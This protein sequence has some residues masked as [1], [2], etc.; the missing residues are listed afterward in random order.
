M[1]PENIGAATLGKSVLQTFPIFAGRLINI[2]DFDIGIG[3][4]VFINE[5]LD[6]GLWF[7]EA[8]V[9]ES[10]GGG[11]FRKIQDGSDNKKSSNE[12]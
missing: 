5:R 4:L 2:V 12:K 11:F 6:N 9:S 7:P 3:G 10:D 8:P 1:N